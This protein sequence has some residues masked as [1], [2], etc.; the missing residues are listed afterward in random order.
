LG[1]APSTP[2][3]GSGFSLGSAPST[4]TPTRT[5]FSFA[6]SPSTTTT[7]TPSTGAGFWCNTDRSLRKRKTAP[8]TLSTGGG[9]SFA[10]SPSTTTTTTPSTGAG[11]SFAVSPSSTSTSTSTTTTT[12]GFSFA[13]LPTTPTTTT[14][15]S[16]FSF[17]STTTETGDADG[18]PVFFPNN[19]NARSWGE[20]PKKYRKFADPVFLEKQLLPA[21]EQDLESEIQK[22]VSNACKLQKDMLR[23]KI[24]KEFI[25]ENEQALEAYQNLLE[26]EDLL[27]GTIDELKS[28]EERV[29]ENLTMRELEL[30]KLEHDAKK[31]SA[32]KAELIEQKNKLNLATVQLSQQKT[33]LELAQYTLNKER[34]EFEEERKL[35]MG[36]KQKMDSLCEQQRGRVILNVGGVQ[37]VTSMTTLCSVPSMLSA[38]FSGRYRFEEDG[39]GCHFIDRDPK[40][41]RLVLNYLR[42]SDVVVPE[43]DKVLI[44]ELYKEATYY[45]I[46]GLQELLCEKLPEL[47]EATEEP[48][49]MTDPYAVD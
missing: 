46:R 30:V 21:T 31:V 40:H 38:M 2:S 33:S 11:F 35:F 19:K 39:D 4:P 25:E 32:G 47:S 37:F 14:T 8:S 5:G 24:W 18:V 45:Q 16:G 34:E 22:F 26:K 23:A 49:D 44:K 15:T 41:F 20:I 3:T 17:P 6:T 9:F 28:E 7:T 29:L 10:T 42:D 1:G 36:E 43:D 48:I 13:T 12:G 27:K